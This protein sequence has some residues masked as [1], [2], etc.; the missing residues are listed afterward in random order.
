MLPLIPVG[1]GCPLKGDVLARSNVLGLATDL[2]GIEAPVHALRNLKVDVSYKFSSEID[3]NA[4]RMV[5]ATCLPETLYNDIAKRD[6]EPIS[7]CG[8]YVAGSPCQ[9]FS[10]AGR[11]EGAN[12][13]LGRG[14]IFYDVHR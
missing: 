13:K 6:N 14:A 4:E 1:L 11:K 5:R 7:K 3:H 2:A 12:D 8:L 9:P 10:T